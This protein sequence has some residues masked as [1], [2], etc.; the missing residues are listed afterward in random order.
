MLWQSFLLGLSQGIVCLGYCLPVVGTYLLAEERSFYRSLKVLLLFLAG[1]LAGYSLFAV[2]SAAAGK[3]ISGLFLSPLFFP[4]VYIALGVLMVAYGVSHFF[5]GISACRRIDKKCKSSSYAVVLGFIT[6]INIC[7]PFLALFALAAEKG[8]VLYSLL[9]FLSF[10]AAT[11][12]YLLP[13]VFMN[14]LTRFRTIRVSAFA[15]SCIT[16][17]LFLFK[18]MNYLLF[19]LGRN[20]IMG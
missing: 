15:A 5:G 6:G 4:L 9:S 13:V 10:F 2:L 19:H 3:L 11:S 18:G 14:A 16:G 20:N 7:P 1:R 17:F 12:I 8:D